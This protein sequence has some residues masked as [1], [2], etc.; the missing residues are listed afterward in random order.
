MKNLSGRVAL[1][2]A[3]D[4]T[5]FDSFARQPGRRTVEGE[6]L[7]VLARAGVVTDPRAQRYE[8]A[9][10]TDRGVS[11]WWNVCAFDTRADPRSL[12]H[13]R[14][15]P[16]GLHLLGAAA[17]TL[18]FSPRRDAL[19]RSYV[20]HVRARPGFDWSGLRRAAL[21]FQG[22]HDFRG[23]SRRDQTVGSVRTLT[24]VRV[25]GRGNERILRFTAPSFLWEQVRRIVR[26]LVEVGEGRRTV[27]SVRAQLASP[28]QRAVPP[29]PPE[30][31][32]LEHVEVPLVFP[33]PSSAAKR[34]L[35]ELHDSA[36]ARWR[37]HAG[38]AASA[39]TRRR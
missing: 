36:W 9:S 21:L 28:G 32:V 38:L 18:S 23:F 19:G 25:S 1:A 6:L 8:A 33:P 30:P 7:R 27:D 10:R 3:Y 31:L 29:A 17:C 2:F 16:A 15:V 34:R 4:G 13:L 12:P 22:R 39:P 20:Y 24:R 14:H 35:E 26:A 37:F 11:A 5:S